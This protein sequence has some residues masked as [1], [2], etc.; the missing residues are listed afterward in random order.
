MDPTQTKPYPDSKKGCHRAG[1]QKSCRELLDEGICQGRWQ[2]VTGIDL[3]T[4]KEIDGFG[5]V[6]DLQGILQQSFEYRLVGIQKAVE[7]RGDDTVAAVAGLVRATVEIAKIEQQRHDEVMGYASALSSSSSRC[8]I[9]NPDE[10]QQLE[11][12]E[13]MH[14]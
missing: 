3:S 4:G 14:N 5:C 11:F 8:E 12:A 7:K 9:P 2:H 1:F 6:D 10:P 13:V